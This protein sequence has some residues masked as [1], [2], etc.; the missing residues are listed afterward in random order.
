MWDRK[1]E[2]EQ[3]DISVLL[4]LGGFDNW[5]GQLHENKICGQLQGRNNWLAG[6]FFLFIN[7][8]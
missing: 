4:M 7:N 5:R 3:S 8:Q 1:K 2:V 6:F